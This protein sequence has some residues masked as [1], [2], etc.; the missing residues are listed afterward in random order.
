MNICKRA[1]IVLL[2]GL[3]AAATQVV[4]ACPWSAWQTFKQQYISQEGRVIDPG[5]PRKI[6]TSE[7]QSYALFFALVADDRPA[8]DQ[9]LTWTSNNL[10][11]GSIAAHLPAWLWGHDGA[12]NRWTVLDTNSASDADMWIAYAL[13]EAGRLWKQHSYSEQGEKL[14]ANIA[15]R[16]VVEV[17]NLGFV[18]LPGAVGFAQK[19]S[20]RLNPSYLPPQILSRIAS[21][22]APWS[23]MAKTHLRLLEE[24]S[25][26]GFAPD[27]AT[28]QRGRGWQLTKTPPVIG[29]YDAIRVYLWIGMLSNQDP[30]KARLL[31]HF[32][33]M[34]E[35][36]A[37]ADTPPEKVNVVSGATQGSGP[38]GFSA[39]LLPMLE[40]S[41][42]LS[43]S[44]QR[45]RDNFPKQN[46]Y[47][48]Y[49]LTLFGQGW[50]QQ[51]FRFNVQGEVV[52]DWGP[53]C[54][55]PQ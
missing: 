27:W 45:I 16:E 1:K 10:A 53:V 46:A 35:A 32:S 39:A 9:I 31:R 7:G 4:A 34:V 51:R 23:K 28:W 29:S 3:M 52:P 30:L 12:N 20:W 50:D 22:G 2:V 21:F 8:F 17:P 55:N 25:P 47:Y 40:E 13:L 14:L 19:Q 48:S 6:T 37:K 54:A 44:R 24:S 15:K 41:A 5:D 49:V 11:Q 36:L 33:P 38:V 43:A 26:K 42:S 18:L